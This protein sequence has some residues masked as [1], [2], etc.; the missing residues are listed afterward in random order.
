MICVTKQYGDFAPFYLFTCFTFIL[1]IFSCI[2]DEGLRSQY[3]YDGV[4]KFVFVEPVRNFIRQF[5]MT[6]LKCYI[7]FL[8]R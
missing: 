1:F 6:Y 7:I 5:K 4:Y 8:A 2:V 3:V